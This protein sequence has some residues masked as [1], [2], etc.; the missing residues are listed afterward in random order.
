[1]NILE[2]IAAK[3]RE[4][5]AEAKNKVS[6]EEMKQK[7]ESLDTDTGF[8][9]EKAIKDGSLSFICEAKKASPSKGLI[10]K[11]FPYVEIAEEYEKGGASAIS[12]LTEPYWFMGSNEYLKEIRAAVNIPIIRKDFTVDGYMIYEAKVIGA[13]AVLLICAIL[14]DDSLKKYIQIADK[15]GLSALVEVHDEEEVKR[16]IVAGARLIGV[17]NRDLRNFTVDINNS[18]RLRNLVP[19]DITFVSESG[20]K[21]E[22]EIKELAE[23]KVDGVLIGETMMRAGESRV[24]T[25]KSLIR[26]SVMNN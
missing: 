21:G 6:L 12:V 16:A 14:D 1:M 3:T 17:N 24:E 4:R 5:V 26:A 18:L 20:I 23:G 11:D 9:F 22:K 10:A 8:P 19:E 13:D 7:A 2:E 25:L 15:L